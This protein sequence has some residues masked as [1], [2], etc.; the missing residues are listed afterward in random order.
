MKDVDVV[1]FEDDNTPYIPAN[2]I[3]NQ[4]EDL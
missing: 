2:K 3:T 4:A 1:S